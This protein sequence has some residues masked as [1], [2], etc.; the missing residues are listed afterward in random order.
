MKSLTKFLILTESENCVKRGEQY[1]KGYISVEEQSP[2]L[3]GPRTGHN[4]NNEQ[5]HT[6]TWVDAHQFPIREGG[7]RKNSIKRFTKTRSNGLFVTNDHRN[8]SYIVV[9]I[10]PYHAFLHW[11][12]K[13]G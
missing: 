13:T 3:A 12:E 2:D 4:A 6:E 5:T 1:T 10:A 8:L 9:N 11:N 7:L